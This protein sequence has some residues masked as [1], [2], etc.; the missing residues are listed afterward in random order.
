MDPVPALVTQLPQP[1]TP[2]M[3][4]GAK[5]ALKNG[6]L[7]SVLGPRGHS[8]S[9]CRRKEGGQRQAACPDPLCR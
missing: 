1:H 6:D 9:I 5:A 4:L 2:Q 3:R 7:P 8:E